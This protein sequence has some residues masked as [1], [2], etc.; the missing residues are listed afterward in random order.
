MSDS[1]LENLVEDSYA[2]RLD[3]NENR[4]R[5]LL[6]DYFDQMNP[7]QVYPVSIL[8]AK[9]ELTKNGRKQDLLTG[10]SRSE[11]I[12]EMTLAG[13]A[14]LEIEVNYPGCLVTPLKQSVSSQE[15]KVKVVFFVTPLAKG[16][17]KGMI[18]ISQENT[19]IFSMEIK[20]KVTDQRIAKIISLL[21]L[22][23]AAVPS[24]TKFLTGNDPN[25]QLKTLLPGIL[26]TT[27]DYL[28]IEISMAVILFFIAGVFFFR[29]QGKH[30]SLTSLDF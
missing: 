3:S 10:E 5:Y 8:I 2:S 9:H 12:G 14:P 30:K 16:K 23:V 11:V 26:A 7:Y 20:Y 13:E 6:I 1:F 24:L 22:L 4:N 15:D 29:Y 28:V 25:E 19:L 18:K 27:S 17:L 21:G